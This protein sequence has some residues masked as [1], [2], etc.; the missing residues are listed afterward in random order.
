MLKIMEMD[1][2]EKKPVGA[3]IEEGFKATSHSIVSG[4]AVEYKE[5]ESGEIIEKIYHT[6]VGDFIV[7]LQAVKSMAEECGVSVR[8]L[9][10]FLDSYLI[11]IENGLNEFYKGETPKDD[12]AILDV[13]NY[14]STSLEKLRMINEA[15][16]KT[17]EKAN[18]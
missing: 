6:P 10:D 15:K 12:V 8:A 7:N 3:N 5:N 18:P 14:M 4:E 17:N 1:N 2:P 16:E 11:G 9:E 13:G